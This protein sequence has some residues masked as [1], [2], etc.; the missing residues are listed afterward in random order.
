MRDTVAEVKERTRSQYRRLPSGEAKANWLLPGH[1]AGDSPLE[2]SARPYRGVA[3]GRW[4]DGIWLDHVA[5]A[6]GTPLWLV[7]RQVWLVSEE[8]IRIIVNS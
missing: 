3:G 5:S 8:F 7:H 1:A 6:L 4:A 2:C